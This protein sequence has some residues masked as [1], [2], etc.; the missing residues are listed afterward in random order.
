MLLGHNYDNS[1]IIWHAENRE[2]TIAPGAVVSEPIALA[3]YG[4]QLCVCVGAGAR[5]TFFDAQSLKNAAVRYTLVLEQGSAVQ[6]RLELFDNGQR[7]ARMACMQEISV[8]GACAV[9]VSVV[10]R[11]Q[12]ASFAG[13][14]CVRDFSGGA[15]E[16]SLAQQH[17]A[18]RTTSSFMVRQALISGSVSSV[19]GAISV[20]KSAHHVHAEQQLQGVM[21]EPE[22]DG[23][24]DCC[25]ENVLGSPSFCMRPTLAVAN[26]TAMVKHGCAVGELDSE[27]LFYMQARGVP[28]RRAKELL[29][30]AFFACP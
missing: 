25:P 3:V 1:K 17:E 28:L 18:P 2:L 29:L 26:H 10:L 4:Q 16:I 20:D 5:V 22:V 12:Q 9:S 19:R 11:G 13:V 27:Q 14:L 6:Y 23:K 21:F 8:K 15:L 24:T 7:C 30:T